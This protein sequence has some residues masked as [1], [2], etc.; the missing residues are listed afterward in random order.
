V[1]GAGT[2]LKSSDAPVE[3]GKAVSRVIMRTKTMAKEQ[4]HMES[5]SQP[6]S[7]LLAR[8][9]SITS[10]LPAAKVMHPSAASCAGLSCSNVVSGRTPMWAAVTPA[11]AA[12]GRGGVTHY[13]FTL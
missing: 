3:A 4:P 10:S 12:Q 9:C 6:T 8:S 5:A 7:F 1:L 2:C 11:C 13:R